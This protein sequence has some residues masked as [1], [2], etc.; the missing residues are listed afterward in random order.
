MTTRFRWGLLI[1]LMLG[2]LSLVAACNDDDGGGDATAATATSE[3]ADHDDADA[4]ADH[5]DA[6]ADADHDDADTDADHDDADEDADHDD[7]AIAFQMSANTVLHHWEALIALQAD[8]LDDAR[9][10]VEHIAEAVSADATHAGAMSDV[11]VALDAADVHDAEHGI[12][13]MLAGRAERDLTPEVLHLQMALVA[14]RAD[15]E[16]EARHQ[17]GHLAGSGA[18]GAD[19]QQLIAFLDDGHHDEAAEQLETMIAAL[20]GASAHDD[21]EHGHEAELEADREITV[22]MTEFA[23]EPEVIRAK[24][25][26]RVRLVID[27]RGAV[28]HDLTT[29]DFDG[30]VQ[31][32]GGVEQHESSAGDHH[33]DGNAFHAAVN[34]GETAELVF[35]A[36]E[37][38]EYTLFCSVP[39]HLQLGMAMTLIIEQ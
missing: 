33:G 28:L 13:V 21:D 16:A 9:H 29:E 4:D 25:G 23:Y 24:V 6:D 37:P 14:V 15:E 34:G 7:G 35:E 31:T 22:V 36:H 17:I 20:G 5:D 38:G 3:D 1:V 26:E 2:A 12:E 39:G 18:D 8:D 11:L 27:N 30:E 10:H 32:T 19:T